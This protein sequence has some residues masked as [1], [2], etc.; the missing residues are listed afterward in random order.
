[1]ES[2]WGVVQIGGQ[3]AADVLHVHSLRGD[4]VQRER[5][6]QDE[7][8]GEQGEIVEDDAGGPGSRTDDV[9][10]PGEDV[11]SDVHVLERP[12]R[13]DGDVHRPGLVGSEFVVVF[14][15]FIVLIVLIVFFI[16]VV[17]MVLIVVNQ[18]FG[19]KIDLRVDGKVDETVHR[20]GGFEV[21]VE[22]GPN[23]GSPQ[24]PGLIRS[25]R[26][27]VDDVVVEGRGAWS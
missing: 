1:M 2:L 13:L 7:L 9:E 27:P 19:V 11:G 22:R 16:V 18:I 15:V 3:R 14:I 6:H 12:R 23:L 10:H 5:T 24:R 8:G 17:F 4:L 25:L 20:V 21:G 26:G